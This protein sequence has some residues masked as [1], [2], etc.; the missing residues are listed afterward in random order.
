MARILDQ[1]GIGFD[2]DASDLKEKFY[3]TNGL[4]YVVQA[5]GRFPDS[6]PPWAM[7]VCM[8]EA[9]KADVA[10]K[11]GREKHSDGGLMD[12]VLEY[13]LEHYIREN[14]GGNALDA[15]ENYKPLSL[16]QAMKDVLTRKGWADRENASEFD[17][18]IRTLSER[19]REER[20]EAAL[21]FLDD[22]PD[23]LTAEILRTGL[24]RIAI[25]AEYP[26]EIKFGM[27]F[28]E[29]AKRIFFDRCAED[30]GAPD[31]LMHRQNYMKKLGG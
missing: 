23:I 22:N 3:R 25:A 14:E 10:A 6:P 7:F 27:Q 17:N 29:R 20:I 5:I 24:E 31:V 12:E 26:V 28:T 8:R 4:E 30:Y 9:V 19:F 16:M 2:P 11:K 18:R 15:L 21:Q 13:Q 1:I